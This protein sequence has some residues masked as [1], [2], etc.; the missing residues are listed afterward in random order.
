VQWAYEVDGRGA[1]RLYADAN[2]LPTAFAPAWG[3]CPPD[4]QPWLATMRF[5]FSEEN[6]GYCPGSYGGLGS[7]HT[8]GTWPL[9]DVQE[10]V[11]AENADQPDRAERAL[12]RLT[13]VASSDGL[14]PEAYDPATGRWTA[15][16]WFAWPAAVVGALA[17]PALGS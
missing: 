9:G 3:F 10:W 2:D 8:P 15:R 7:L 13:K 1:S 12:E 14:L 4:H 11:A 16:H 17:L 6:P 5:A